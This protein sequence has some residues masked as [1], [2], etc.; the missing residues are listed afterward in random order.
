MKHLKVPAN[1]ETLLRK[2]CCGNIVADGN[3]C[4]RTQHLLRNVSEF[5]QKHFESATNISPFP[6]QGSKTFV[7]IP[8]R[9]LAVETLRATMFPQQ[10]FLVYGAL[11]AWQ[12]EETCFPKHLYCAHVSPMFPSFAIRETLFPTTTFASEKQNMFLQH[13]RN[14]PCFRDAW[15]AYFPMFPRQHYVRQI[16]E[17]KALLG[18][19]VLCRQFPHNG[20][21][22]SPL[23]SSFQ[24]QSIRTVISLSC[25][26]P[27]QMA[28]TT[29]S[30][31]LMST[32]AI[33]G[34]S[35]C[36]KMLLTPV[37][38]CLPMFPE[39]PETCFLV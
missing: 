36:N 30:T 3:V 7:L 22:G 20:F 1:E 11:K 6:Q 12:N 33:L 39:S 23:A 9:L 18:G 19:R 16:T 14:I 4:A 29:T 27:S 28:T 24:P 10:C 25:S 15:K 37:P 32:S 5:F 17:H 13:G 2:H 26:S 34:S 8:T 35:S 31:T 21:K 38:M